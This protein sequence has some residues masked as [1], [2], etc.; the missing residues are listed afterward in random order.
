MTYHSD[1][2]GP[3]LPLTS[4]TSANF[5]ILVLGAG[6]EQIDLVFLDY[7]HYLLYNV[8]NNGLLY[9]C[10]YNWCLLKKEKIDSRLSYSRYNSRKLS[11]SQKS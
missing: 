8:H 3:A 11:T 2:C 6:R 10:W 1:K 4:H 5:L 9:H 7:Y